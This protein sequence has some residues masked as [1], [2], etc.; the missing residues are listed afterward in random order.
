MQ[1]AEN[2]DMSGSPSGVGAESSL[3]EY[4]AVTIGKK[5][6]KFRSNLL[7]PRSGYTRS[8]SLLGLAGAWI[9]NDALQLF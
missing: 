6:P 1:E 8:E 5:L 7:S 9:F 3:L 2:C 4:E